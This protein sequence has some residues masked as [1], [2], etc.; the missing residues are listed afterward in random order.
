M[1]LIWKIEFLQLL[2]EGSKN[3]ISII[4]FIKNLI[5]NLIYEQ[6]LY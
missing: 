6:L 3:N 5:N 1:F 2:Y 4:T